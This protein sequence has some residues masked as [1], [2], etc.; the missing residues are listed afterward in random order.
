M[1]LDLAVFSSDFRSRGTAPYRGV[2]DFHP[3]FKEQFL[4][5]PIMMV[6]LLT[7]FLWC[8]VMLAPTTRS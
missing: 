6:I 3:S 2:S 4:I 5:L 1:N 8:F 7:S